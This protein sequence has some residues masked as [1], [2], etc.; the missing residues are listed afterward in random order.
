MTLREKLEKMKLKIPPF[1]EGDT[2][3]RDMLL[4]YNSY[5]QAID[6]IMPVIEEEMR[7]KLEEKF[8]LLEAELSYRAKKEGGVAIGFADGITVGQTVILDLIHALTN[9]DKK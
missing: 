7:G 2:F 6:E 8:A 1:K 9:Q 5:N 3:T 4:Q